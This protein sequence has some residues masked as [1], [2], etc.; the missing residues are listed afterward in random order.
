MSLNDIYERNFDED[1]P[2]A[3]QSSSGCPECGGLVHTNSIETVCE[4]CGLLIE[5]RPIDDGQEW[6]AF[7]ETERDDRERTGP[8]LT[9]ARHDRGL[10]SEIGF[11]RTDANGTL[12]P[13]RKNQQLA[14]LRRE[15]R[16]GRWASKAEQNLAHGLSDVR[17]MSGVLDLPRSL[18]DRACQIFR[19][20]AGDGLLLGRSIEAMTAASVYAAC[21]CAGLP[22]ALEE[23]TAVATVSH[24][25]VQNAY[26]VLNRE[27]RLPAMT[28]GPA[29]YIPR[30]ASELDI[31]PTIR[32]RAVD[33]AC[34]LVAAGAI[35]GCKPAGIAAACLYQA[36]L[37]QRERVTQRVL[38]DAAGI[39]PVTLRT[40]WKHLQALLND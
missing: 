17:R 21:R 30:L 26:T 8:P 6:R 24:D 13:G 5:D 14:R 9:P 34:V 16:R 23:V 1:V 11:D 27:L 35:S 15:D 28:V 22:R 19:I 20:A 7:D 10:S 4:D 36:G 40:R 12:L 3:D 32:R 18:R 31:S 33:L 37:E 25:R 38:A 2:T 39:T 29:E